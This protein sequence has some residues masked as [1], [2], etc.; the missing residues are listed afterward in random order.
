MVRD[1]T[2]FHLRPKTLR[3][4]QFEVLYGQKT[5]QKWAGIEL[6]FVYC[7]LQALFIVYEKIL[8]PKLVWDITSF[9]LIP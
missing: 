8:K 4:D 3:L 5:A 2:S 6:N 1:I 7:A 9:H